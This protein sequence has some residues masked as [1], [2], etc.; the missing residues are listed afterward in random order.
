MHKHFAA[1]QRALRK[2]LVTLVLALSLTSF[3]A[4]TTPAQASDHG[5]TCLLCLAN[6]NGPMAVSACVGDILQLFDDLA[7]LRPFPECDMAGNS[8]AQQGYSYY[9]DC[10]AGTSALDSGALAVQ[11]AAGQQYGP[12][13]FAGY[14]GPSHVVGIGT[15]GNY[16]PYSFNSD[17][18]NANQ[19]TTKICVGNLVGNTSVSI[20][21]GDG[22]TYAQAGVYDNIVS[23][24]P[25]SQ[26]RYIDVFVEG[27]LYRRVRW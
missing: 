12:F 23:M 24:S 27:A 7:H 21:S 8:Q 4:F 18:Y 22:N 3:P 14:S 10:P 17:S 15:G 5:C 13:G 25:V 1:L 16:N 9:D 20:S 11:G 6:P 2:T 26:P 19:S